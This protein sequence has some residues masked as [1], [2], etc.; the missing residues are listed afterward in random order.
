[1]AIHPSAVVDPQADIHPDA[2]VGPFCVVE[3]GA[4][5]K[6]GVILLN[7]VTISGRCTLGSG[8]KVF[9]GAVIGSEP[10]D[11]KY[12]GEASE[13]IIGENNTIHECVT[14]SRGTTGGGMQTVLGHDNLIMAYAHIAHDCRLGNNIVVGNETQLAGHIIVEDRAII[15]GMAGIHHFV[16]IGELSFVAGMSTVKKD[17]PPYTMM[18]GNPAEVRGLNMLGLS[19]AGWSDEELDAMKEAYRI[20]YFDKTKALSTSI[21]TV[22]KMDIGESQYVDKLCTWI[23]TMLDG[24]IKGRMQESAR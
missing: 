11:L 18:E 3:S 24:S 20:M 14:I 23:Q 16:T 6:A 5:L 21:E 9:P 8:T 22:R 4:I 2:E 19:R 1:M 12:R 17:I 10:Q 7:N 15:S 13:V